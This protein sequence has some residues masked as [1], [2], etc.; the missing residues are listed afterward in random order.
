[1]INYFKIKKKHN[2]FEHDLTE[3]FEKKMKLLS[4]LIE[5]GNMAYVPYRMCHNN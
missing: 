3:R 5:M 4:Q 1:M 2:Y